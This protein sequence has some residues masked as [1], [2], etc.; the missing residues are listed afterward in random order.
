[1]AQKER[2]IIKPRPK[3]AKEAAHEAI[4]ESI[5][6]AKPPLPKENRR[7]EQ[8]SIKG[9]TGKDFSIGFGDIDQAVLYYFDN[10]IQPSVIEDGN[11]VKVPVMYASPERWKSAQ[12]DGGI[13]DKDGKILF[14]IIAVKK[15]DIMK[16]R[17]ITSKLDGNKARNFYV[18]EQKYSRQNAYDNFSALSNRKPV[19][20]Y[21]V[22]VIPDYYKI[23]YSCSVYVNHVRDLNRIL[24]SILYASDSYWGDPKR[25]TFMA[26]IDNTPITQEVN[27]G[28]IRKIY[29]TFNI[30]LNGH[31]IPDSINKYMSSGSPKAFSKA[32]ITFSTEIV[33]KG[34]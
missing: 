22:V 3:T 27:V 19:K 11:R 33:N 5:P 30:T 31:V 26:R 7:A 21:G 34:L 32:Q 17:D 16:V 4:V 14:P 29:S 23:T 6:G 9:D 25:F 28:D 12:A 1:M 24:E 20:T 2:K 18:Y 10:V 8:I 15:D 13:R